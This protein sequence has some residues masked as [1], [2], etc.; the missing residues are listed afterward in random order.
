MRM[1]RFFRR[2]RSDFDLTREIA[3]HINEERAEYIAR[4]LTPEEADRL[5]RIK[6]G[7]ARRV[8]EDLWY[9]NSLA[10]LEGILRDLKYAVR[11]LTHAPG[12]ALTVI[13]IMALGIGANTAVFSVMNAVLLKSLPVTDPQRVVYLYIDGQPNG[14]NNTGNS[15]S[16]FSWPV[17]D[18]LRH[19][20]HALSEVMAYVPL[21]FD[22]KT[23]V[24]IDAAPEVAEGD[25]ASGN[26][27][28]GLGVRITRG[29]G[30]TSDDETHHAP[31]AIL[32]YNYWTRRFSR[33]PGVLGQ[34]LFVKGV[35]L[36]IVG[37]SAQGFEG[38]EPGDSVDFW[39]PLQSR[40]EL[41]AWG[42]PPNDGKTYLA[43]P[44][45][46]CLRLLARLAPGVS[47]KQAIARTQTVLA[48]A[49]FIGLGRPHP[50]QKPPVLTL[51]PAKAFPGYA[52]QYGTPLKMMMAMVAL[53]LLIA[54]SNVVMLLIARNANRQREFSV[55][56]SLGAGRTQL[57]RQLLTE[58]ALLVALGGSLAWLFACAG[59]RAL[60]AW[61]QI[62]SSLSPDATALSVTLGILVLAAFLFGLAPLRTS[63]AGGTGLV[64]KSASAVTNQS[65]GGSRSARIVIALQMA[66]CLSLL[67]GAGLLVRTLRNLEN[68]P[69]GFRPGGLVVFGINPQHTQTPDEGI[70]FYQLLL[71]R[72]RALP[73]VESVSL[74]E[75]RPGSG[76]SNNNGA[77][78]IDGHKP[79]NS[80]GEQG[81][82]RENAIG[83]DYFHTLG[84]PILAGRDFTDADTARAPKAAIVNQT[85]AK[86]FL[87]GQS[88][89][90]HSLIFWGVNAQIVGVVKDHKYTGVTEN[91]RP[92]LWLPYTQSGAPGEM[93]V[94]MRVGYRTGK[95]DPLAILPAA[96]N[97]VRQIDPDL[98][99]LK[100][101]LQQ[102]QF[103]Q[104]ISQQILFARLA[105]CFGL[106]AILLVATGIYGTLAYRVSRR[107]AEI[108]VRMAL[109][110]RRGQVV[111]MVLRS[112]LWLTLIGVLAGV[113]LAILISRTL[114]SA[115]YQ[116][117]PLDAAPYIGAVL[118]LACVTLAASAVPAQRAARL[119]PAKALRSE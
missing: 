38:T 86:R 27:F 14:A 52:E 61:A 2:H 67:V 55:R 20:D 1:F 35:P 82:V 44:T 62:D 23:A 118:C 11:S 64:L 117:K 116:V 100:P 26:F 113:P 115:L 29:R 58:S 8:H 84:V 85:F 111:W 60:A 119:D 17:Y 28:S 50:G 101:L 37:I 109:G 72:L 6:F 16:S 53:V 110:A 40:A 80:D 7:S 31:V 9:Q 43:Q 13:L 68:T 96:Q 36:T 71:S 102:A 73:G 32:S 108:G 65:V 24:R 95:G 92:M 59:T 30:F 93:H 66:F 114:A 94:E 45:W 70:A 79:P 75:N 112:S 34:T 42:N 21:S 48:Q 78:Q 25:M 74:A 49:A 41:N 39:I 81:M 105:E 104:S 18:A 63:L 54:L 51:A 33:A 69:L 22:G 12:F 56:L 97:A 76:W 87:P 46:W 91:T 107:T 106:L 103:D 10:F 19:Q 77:P 5:A 90:G 88:A 98:P 83:S 3:A 57:F 99:L 89:V 47:Q 15:D 4:G